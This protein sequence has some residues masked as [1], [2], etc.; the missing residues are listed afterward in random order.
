M[1]KHMYHR[2]WDDSFPYIQH[3]YKLAQQNS[4]EK[5]LFEVYYGFY[6]LK[7]IDLLNQLTIY[8]DINHEQQ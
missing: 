3:S 2:T 4:I 5:T 1:Y 6:L 8:F 7:P